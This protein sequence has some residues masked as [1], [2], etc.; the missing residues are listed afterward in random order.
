MLEWAHSVTIFN[1][2]CG[3]FDVATLNTKTNTSAVASRKRPST[4]HETGHNSSGS[5]SAAYRAAVIDIACG[6]W[7]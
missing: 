5:I 7:C 3:E 2:L 6:K 1:A 4:R